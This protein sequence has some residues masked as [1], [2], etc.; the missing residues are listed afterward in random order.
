MD[1]I[2]S[3]PAEPAGQQQKKKA[4]PAPKVVAKAKPV[5]PEPAPRPGP[6]SNLPNFSALDDLDDMSPED[7][8]P[9]FS[10]YR[11]RG[12]REVRDRKPTELFDISNATLSTEVLSEIESSDARHL[13]VIPVSVSGNR[14]TIACADP[15]DI[16]IL[17]KLRPLLAGKTVSLVAADAAS[18]RRRIDE[19]YSARHEA[20]KVAQQ[21]DEA[22][23]KAAEQVETGQDLGRVGQGLEG[24]NNKLLRLIIEQ[25][26]R[27]L[28]S[29][30][31]L[32]PNGHGIEVRNRID[33]KLHI[34]GTYPAEVERGLTTLVKVESQMRTDNRR[35]PD[36]GV[37]LFRPKGSAK[38]VDIRV[39][40]APCAWGQ[41]VVMRLQNEVW[42]DLKTLGFS[43]ENEARFRRAIAQPY[44]VILTTGPTGSGKTTTLYSA[45][46]ERINSETKIITLE[47]PIEFK[48]PEGVTQM[49]VNDEQ[50]M[51]FTRGLRSIVRQDPDVVLIGEIRDQETAETAVDAAMTGHL[52]FSTLHTNDAVGAVPRMTRLGIEPFLLSS[53]LLAVIGQRLVRRLCTK[54]KVPYQDEVEGKTE[55]IF[56]PNPEGCLECFAGYA[57]RVPIHEVLLV[58]DSLREL[59]ANDAGQFDILTA[60]R[61]NGMTSMREDGWLKVR[62][63]IT[64]VSEI[65]SNTRS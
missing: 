1:D 25:G 8:G 46:R 35:T 28:A 18:I 13:N 32:E 51:T 26:I 9:D 16:E 5:Q 10:Q 60:A 55:D 3:D 15:S 30:I 29:D 59:V 21:L 22:E 65:V 7:T 12:E 52:V 57:G 56:K 23:A 43:T 33:G 48:I 2:F 6:P 11:H 61:E 64:S 40:T 4:K 63:G 27:E 62:E 47:N 38:A 53:S 37:L 49:S 17:N 45:V 19:V 42:R 20:A 36:S 24:Q 34:R 14:V 31:H 39:E 44:G 54:C 58:D 41:T 50:G